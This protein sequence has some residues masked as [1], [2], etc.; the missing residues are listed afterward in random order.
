MAYKHKAYFIDIPLTQLGRPVL[1]K[2]GI[3][4]NKWGMRKGELKAFTR[5]VKLNPLF[6]L[7]LPFLYSYSL[8]KHIFKAISGR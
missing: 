7:S 8:G 1:S 3:S 2:G 5:L 6:I 4:A